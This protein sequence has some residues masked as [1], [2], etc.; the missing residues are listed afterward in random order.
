MTIVLISD[1][2]DQRFACHQLAEQLRRH[3]RHCLTVG[4]SK[5]TSNNVSSHL[6]IP[7]TDVELSSNE[8]L[9][10]GLLENA[11][12]IG[13]FLEDTHQEKSF[14]TNYRAICRNRQ[15]TPVPLFGGAI[16]VDVGDR[17]IATL[18]ERQHLDL[19]LVP[20][21]RHHA[22]A[23]AMTRHWPESLP[24]PVILSVGLWFMPERP[25]IGSLRG[26]GSGSGQDMPKTL[27]A[28]VQDTIPTQVGGKTQLLKQLFRWAEQSP[29]WTVVVARDYPSI[30][31][32]PWIKKF[33]PD[34]WT[35][36]AN[37]A[38]AAPGQM[39]PLLANCSACITVSSTW[40]M[41]PIC[42][43]RRCLVIGDFG[44]HTDQGTTA[45]FGSGLMHRLSA[46]RQL[47]DVLELPAVNSNWLEALGWAHHDG[48]DRLIRC[49]QEIRERWE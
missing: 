4:G 11:E 32:Q 2:I 1:G 48:P 45:F 6:P 20:G 37:A 12:A 41:A 47:D 35:F 38:F 43:G 30:G 28:L 39:L 27:V 10:T 5:Q 24:C 17:L 21:D 46:I 18:S 16:S 42:W 40:A 29:D 15:Q 23:M 33:N 44:I 34:D 3:G 22:E 8:L 14:A 26:S 9:G 19:V 36:P 7:A 31:Q 49:L 25:P 13:L